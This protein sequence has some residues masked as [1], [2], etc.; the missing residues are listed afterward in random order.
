MREVPDVVEL[1]TSESVANTY[2]YAKGNASLRPAGLGGGRVRVQ[3]LEGGRSG[4][5]QAEAG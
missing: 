2:Q 3:V 5:A 4:A 1:L